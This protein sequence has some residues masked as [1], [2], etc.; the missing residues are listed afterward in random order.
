[1]HDFFDRRSAV[2]P[3]YEFTAKDLYAAQF[4]RDL[5][6]RTEPYLEPR[7]P[8]AAAAQFHD[9]F[10][11]MYLAGALLDANLPLVARPK[12]RQS[13]GG[14]D[15]QI[16]Q[17]EAWV[18]AVVA[19]CGTAQDR[20]LPEEPRSQWVQEPE[21][22]RRIREVINRKHQ[23]YQ[24]DLE[25]EYVL[26]SEPYVIAINGGMLTYARYEDDIPRIVR[27]AFGIGE[28]TMTID[29]HAGRVVHEG[30]APMPMVTTSTDTFPVAFFWRPE[31]SF[32]SAMIWGTADAQH[33]P[34]MMGHDLITV[35]NPNASSPLPRGWLRQG[36]EYWVQDDNLRCHDW[37]IG[38]A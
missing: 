10:W 31:F 23:R 1:M 16:G 17:V 38:E 5:W 13:A 30:Y 29:V 25:R 3:S 28:H 27:A 4:V 24:E 22:V 14:P 37:R 9:T 33:R 34:A 26:P 2:D 19:H 21:L 35:Y 18:E 15:I 8:D 11:E 32:I 12:R 36:L 20:V 6:H 7:R